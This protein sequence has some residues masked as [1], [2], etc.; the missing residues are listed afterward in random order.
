ML[1]AGRAIVA[2]KGVL[3]ND[4]FQIFQNILDR[5]GAGSVA[6]LPP[7]AAVRAAI[8]SMR[9]LFIDVLGCGPPRRGMA[10]LGAGLLLAFGRRRLGVHRPL[11]RRRG[12]MRLLFVQLCNSIRGRQNRQLNGFGAELGQLQRLLFRASPI[13]YRLDNVIEAVRWRVPLFHP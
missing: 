4:C 5:P 13:Q 2:M 6:A 11:S 12:R 10:P 8:E 7:A 3:G 9:L 1:V